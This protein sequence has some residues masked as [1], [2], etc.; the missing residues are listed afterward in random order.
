MTAEG[1]GRQADRV[2]LNL[3]LCQVF[4]TVCQVG[5]TGR[6]VRLQVGVCLAGPRSLFFEVSP[7]DLLAC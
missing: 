6:G 4:L 5:L 2:P 1:A 3:V 7:A